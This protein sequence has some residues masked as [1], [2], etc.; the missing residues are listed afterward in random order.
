MAFIFRILYV[1]NLIFS[2]FCYHSLSLYTSREPCIYL[3]LPGLCT[4]CSLPRMTF[5]PLL[6]PFYPLVLSLVVTS[7]SC[8]FFHDPPSM[9]QEPF[10]CSSLSYKLFYCDIISIYMS[11]YPHLKIIEQES[12]NLFFQRPDS[13]YF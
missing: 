13:K 2:L 8:H 3:S 1:P 7:F 6:T 10:F 5:L 12:A 11:T 4:C 9:D